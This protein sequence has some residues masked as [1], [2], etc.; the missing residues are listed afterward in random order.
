MLNMTG[1]LHKR[2]PG[3]VDYPEEQDA[4][5]DTLWSKGAEDK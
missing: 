3:R 2:I 1:V 5:L 4:K